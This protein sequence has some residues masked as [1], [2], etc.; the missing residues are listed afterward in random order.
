[1]DKAT[2][3]T[4]AKSLW[5]EGP[6]KRNLCS[7]SICLNTLIS[8]YIPTC[9]RSSYIFFLDSKNNNNR[10]FPHACSLVELILLELFSE[11]ESTQEGH[12]KL[13]IPAYSKE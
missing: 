11:V 9:I 7:A 10:M 1:M 2:T 8:E 13:S 4:D 12:H 6:D 5:G 3:V